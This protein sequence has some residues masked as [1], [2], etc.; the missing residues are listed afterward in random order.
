MAHDSLS[1]VVDQP[2]NLADSTPPSL[3]RDV[4]YWIDEESGLEAASIVSGAALL[5]LAW[6]VT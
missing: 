4:D 1:P 2:L 6:A 3:P 5:E